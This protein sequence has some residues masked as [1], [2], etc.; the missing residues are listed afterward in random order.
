[1]RK[2]WT[3]REFTQAGLVLGGIGLP[4]PQLAPDPRELLRAAADEIIPETDGMPAASSVG[5]LEYLD[6][7][8]A[9]Y[10]E[11][12][13]QFQSGLPSLETISQRKFG[14]GFL[15]LSPAQRVEAMAELETSSADFFA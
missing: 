7:V 13:R 10:P 3:R 15:S 8:L 14:M 4:S 2:K 6:G 12:D 5:V 11:I 9:Q 1:M